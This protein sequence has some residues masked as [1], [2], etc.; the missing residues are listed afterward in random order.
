[1]IEHLMERIADATKKDPIEVRVLNIENENSSILD[2]IDSFKVDSEYRSRRAAI[3]KFNDENAWKKKGL[4]VS[5]MAFPIIYDGNFPVSISVY[6]ADGTILISH[7]GIEMGQGINTKIAQVCAYMLN[8]PLSI[9][10]VKGSDTF[11]SPNAFATN[12]SITSESVAFAT[13]K[14]CN[15]LLARLEQTKAE[16]NEP[17]WEEVITAAFNKG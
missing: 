1:M 12:G 7:G 16:L 9:V 6:H 10:T 8:V 11:V 3:E 13:M 4:Q 14:A 5:M 17:T 2:M 15:E